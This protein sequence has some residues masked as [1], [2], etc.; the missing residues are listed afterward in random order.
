MGHGWRPRPFRL[1]SDQ[2]GAAMLH[3][4]GGTQRKS[5]DNYFSKN[6]DLMEFCDRSKRCQE[7]DRLKVRTMFRPFVVV[8]DYTSQIIR[9]SNLF[10]CTRF[11]VLFQEQFRETWGLG[12]YYLRMPWRWAIQNSGAGNVRPL[13]QG[14]PFVFETIDGKG[15]SSLYAPMKQKPTAIE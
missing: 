9:L 4:Q 10:E 13:E 14:H 15:K 11:F 12:S 1:A 6:K 2:D 7:R 3:F 8:A 5:S